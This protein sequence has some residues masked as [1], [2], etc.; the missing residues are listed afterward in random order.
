MEVLWKEE[1]SK[2][3]EMSRAS[4]LEDLD[5]LWGP[6]Q[7]ELFC[8]SVIYIYAFKE[9]FYTSV[10]RYLSGNKMQNGIYSCFLV[11]AP[12][13]FCSKCIV[14]VPLTNIELFF[15]TVLYWDS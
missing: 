7:P 14:T 2:P 15:Y 12:L 3:C 4:P 6:F 10:A 11:F 5:D 8:D 9:M 13:F 1:G